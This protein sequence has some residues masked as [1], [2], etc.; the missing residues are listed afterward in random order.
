MYHLHPPV[1]LLVGMLVGV[2]EGETEERVLRLLSLSLSQTNSRYRFKV[3][4][5]CIHL[6]KDSIRGGRRLLVSGRLRLSRQRRRVAR[7][8]NVIIRV[9]TR[10]SN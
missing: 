3:W 5:Y 2:K 10:F 6:V 1:R 4:R 7:V 8:G 9:V